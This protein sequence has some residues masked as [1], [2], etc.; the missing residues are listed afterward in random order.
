[1]ESISGHFVNQILTK[2]DKLKQGTELY[3]F[4]LKVK[5]DKFFTYFIYLQRLRQLLEW[6]KS[7]SMYHLSSSNNYTRKH[8]NMINVPPPHKRFTHAEVSRTVTALL[9]EQCW[10]N[11]AI[12]DRLHILFSIVS[13]AGSES[14]LTLS[15]FPHLILCTRL[16]CRLHYS[17]FF[18]AVIFHS[19]TSR[20]SDYNCWT[21]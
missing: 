14:P 8:Q 17:Q 1:M 4:D 9:V 7:R 21:P 19:H 3:I 10:L 6:W 5:G 12:I 13:I 20:Q 2:N 11:V 16:K 18:V 15:N